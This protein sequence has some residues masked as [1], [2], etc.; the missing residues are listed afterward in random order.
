MISHR[1]TCVWFDNKFKMLLTLTHMLAVRRLAL[2]QYEKNYFG[3]KEKVYTNIDFTYHLLTF[4]I[5]SEKR[6][7]KNC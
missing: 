7:K 1:S 5:I 6:R 3:V 2:Q 4:Q